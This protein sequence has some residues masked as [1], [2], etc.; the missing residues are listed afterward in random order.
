[1]MNDHS[2]LHS[3]ERYDPMN[4]YTRNSTMHRFLFKKSER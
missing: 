1:M 2:I 3:G 4:A